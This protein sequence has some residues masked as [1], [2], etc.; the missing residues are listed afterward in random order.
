[1]FMLC[2]SA[3]Y[4]RYTQEQSLTAVCCSP[5]STWVAISRLCRGSLAA[6]ATPSSQLP[7]LGPSSFSISLAQMQ[8]TCTRHHHAIPEREPRSS[9]LISLLA[10]PKPSLGDA[11][12]AR[13][14]AMLYPRG[15]AMLYPRGLRMLY[16]RGLGMLYPR[17]LAMLYPRLTA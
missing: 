12:V 7:P 16:P 9:P 15:L 11:P 17:G 1:M 4:Y 14:L 10:L 13:G 2:A 5:C 8:C 6:S 3:C